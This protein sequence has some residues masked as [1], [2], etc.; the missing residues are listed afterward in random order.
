MIKGDILV[1]RFND[2]QTKCLVVRLSTLD[3]IMRERD[4][5]CPLGDIAM[6]RPERK[7]SGQGGS[8]RPPHPIANWQAEAKY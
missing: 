6:H 5:S 7:R 4:P 2:Q 1:C 3:A 8:G